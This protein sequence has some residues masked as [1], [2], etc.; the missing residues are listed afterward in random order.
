M[1]DGMLRN[2]APAPR[3]WLNALTRKRA[4]FGISNE[5]S[6]SKNSSYALRCLSFMMSYTMPCTSLWV[7]A[8]MLMRLMSPSTR[9]IGGTPAD[10]CKIGSVI[11]DGKRQQ[12]RNVDSHSCSRSLALVT[13]AS[14]CS[15]AEVLGHQYV[16]RSA[17]FVVDD[18]IL[19][20]NLSAVRAENRRR[21]R[22]RAKLW[23]RIT[24]V[25]VSK[26]HGAGYGC[27]PVERAHGV[28]RLRRELPAG[29]A[30]EN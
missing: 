10:R 13:A 12:L 20:L 9:I 29:G 5:K 15:I 1:A 27:A 11:L 24:L 7:S 3:F 6:V 8:G 17:E 18:A 25:A 21:G 22:R 14:Q 16:N 26:G 4:S 30:A 23:T 28:S 19:T 2:T